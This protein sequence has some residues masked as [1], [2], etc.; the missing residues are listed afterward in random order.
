MAAIPSRGTAA[1]LSSVENN[2][3]FVRTGVAATSLVQ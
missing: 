1:Q 2:H 3:L